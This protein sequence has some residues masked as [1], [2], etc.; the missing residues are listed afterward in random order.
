MV[1][2]LTATNSRQPDLKTTICAALCAV[3]LSICLVSFYRNGR[4]SIDL[5]QYVMPARLWLQ[6]VNPYDWV[7]YDAEVRRQVP[8]STYWFYAN[9]LPPHSLLMT[10]PIAWMS[11]KAIDTTWTLVSFGAMVAALALIVSLFGKSWTRAE[12]YLFIALMAQSRLVQSVAYRGQVALVMLAFTLIALACARRGRHAAAGLMFAAVCM[13]FTLALPLV[14]ILVARRGWRSLAWGIAFIAI[15][16]LI[17]MATIGFRTALHTIPD[18]MRYF[19]SHVAQEATSIGTSQRV[20][21]WHMTN[22]VVLY[23]TAF[24]Q[25]SPV[26]S[27]LSRL[28]LVTAGG[29]LVWLAWRLRDEEHED[30]LFAVSTMFMLTCVY[31]HVYDAVFVFGVAAAFWNLARARTI[32][33]GPDFKLFG[34]VLALFLFVFAVQPLSEGLS[35]RLQVHGALLL[36]PVNAWLGLALLGL[37]YLV[38]ARY[39]AASEPA[40]QTE[41][42]AGLG[43]EQGVLDARR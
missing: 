13:K 31:H 34:A 10:A 5:P 6:H 20:G 38:A 12:Q 39:V 42:P 18:S 16:S 33:L 9:P 21:N 14:V 11:W 24:G 28:T 36:T 22:W 23:A 30:W 7:R 19:S 2:N 29:A 41:L 35:R 3:S 27:V 43:E 37:C 26:T 15:G 1:S 40:R 25:R 17:V 4:A 8:G 32:R